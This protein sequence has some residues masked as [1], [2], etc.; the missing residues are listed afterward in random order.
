MLF[1]E[2]VEIGSSLSKLFKNKLVTFLDTLWYKNTLHTK[3][4]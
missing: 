1:A 3:R 2:M 4:E